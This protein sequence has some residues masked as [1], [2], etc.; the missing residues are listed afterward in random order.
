MERCKGPEA[1]ALAFEERPE[2][3]EGN[4]EQEIRRLAGVGQDQGRCPRIFLP[5]A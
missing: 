4:E 3:V 1:G 5:L 2:Y